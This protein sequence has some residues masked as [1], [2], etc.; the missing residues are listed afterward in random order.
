MITYA[1]CEHSLW[2]SKFNFQILN[3]IYSALIMSIK[4]A[5]SIKFYFE[6]F[7]AKLHYKILSNLSLQVQIWKWTKRTLF[8]TIGSTV[9]VQGRWIKNL[10]TSTKRKSK[11]SQ[12]H[13]IIKLIHQKEHCKTSS[14]SISWTLQMCSLKIEILWN[15]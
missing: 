13:K 10:W 14:K 12:L 5:K 11:K 9:F 6:Q 8:I 15:N 2:K 3:K 7:I 4:L 1:F